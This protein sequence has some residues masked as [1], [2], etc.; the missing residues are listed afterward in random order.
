MRLL[1][2]HPQRPALAEKWKRGP[3]QLPEGHGVAA[4]SL[5]TA[6]QTLACQTAA[7]LPP[8]ALQPR[9]AVVLPPQDTSSKPPAAPNPACQTAA[10][11]PPVALQPL[12]AVVLPPQ[13]TSSKPPAA[14]LNDGGYY[15][16]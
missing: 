6:V 1:A 3:R 10:T 12:L 11:L 5:L 13:D 9:L 14:Y 4:Q 16:F 7:T 2:R 8:E 15:I